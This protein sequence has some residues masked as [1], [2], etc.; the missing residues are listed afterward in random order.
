MVASE[1]II[2]DVYLF[3]INPVNIGIEAVCGVIQ[4]IIPHATVIP[5]KI[6]QVFEGKRPTGR[7][8]Y[9]WVNSN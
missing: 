1:P 9:I 4:I 8:N 3:D 6:T 7:D 5:T 2:A